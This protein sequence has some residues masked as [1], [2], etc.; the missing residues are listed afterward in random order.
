MIMSLSS[1][2]GGSAAGLSGGWNA[3][4]RGGDGDGGGSAPGEALAGGSIAACSAASSTA[5]PPR[6]SGWFR[7][8]STSFAW[9]LKIGFLAGSA[10][11][12]A[13]TLLLCPRSSSLPTAP[14]PP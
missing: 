3:C 6:Q 10:Q 14:S 11:R 4:A 7:A 12:N 8:V 13:K 5:S 2:A 1:E 9:A